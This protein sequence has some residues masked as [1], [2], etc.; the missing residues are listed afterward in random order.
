MC[1]KIPVPS[2]TICPQ[3]T[4]RHE[5]LNITDIVE[6]DKTGNFENY[7]NWNIHKDLV[8]QSCKL[9]HRLLKY[10]N[11]SKI[12][13]YDI[14]DWLKKSQRTIQETLV[15]CDTSLNHQYPC[16]IMFQEVFTE[17]GLCYNFNGLLP[18]DLYRDEV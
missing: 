12:I 11:S 3:N 6:R 2:V 10:E 8:G 17:S 4:F 7:I 13:S 16:N 14:Y 5:A 1:N 18:E 15:H 9:T